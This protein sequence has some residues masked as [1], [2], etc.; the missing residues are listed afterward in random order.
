MKKIT[1]LLL[2]FW[3][4]VL[5]AQDTTLLMQFPDG[6]TMIEI[7]TKTDTSKVSYYTGKQIESIIKR[8]ATTNK[9][10]YIRYYRNGK[11]MWDKEWRNDI[12]NGNCSFYNTKGIRVAEFNYSGGKIIDTLFLAKNTYLLFGSLDYSSTVYGGMQNEDGSSNVSTVS[13][14]YMHFHMKFLPVDAIEPA[15]PITEY[16]FTSDFK[17]EFLVILKPGTFGLFDKN[18]N[19][20]D[21]AKGQYGPNAKRGNSWESHWDSENPVIITKNKAINY[22]DY[23]QTSVGYA[24]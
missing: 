22:R 20:K 17:G 4:T 16:Y 1:L 10:H 19:P 14:P 21:L 13:G 11:K 8:D 5:N 18:F 3:N 2:L 12:E 24:P 6:G 15:K 23:H 9:T 7:R